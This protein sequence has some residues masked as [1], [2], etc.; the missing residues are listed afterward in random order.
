MNMGRPIGC[1]R[2]VR[3]TLGSGWQSLLSYVRHYIT[4]LSPIFLA[5][6]TSYSYT[7]TIKH[8]GLRNLTA[9]T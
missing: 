1:L 4:S 8:L 9:I 2:G 6:P 5:I 3:G 7:A